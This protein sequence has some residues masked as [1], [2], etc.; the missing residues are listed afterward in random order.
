MSFT[1]E[2]KHEIVGVKLNECCKRAQSAALIQLCSSMV[3]RNQAIE[4]V[5]KTENAQTAKRIFQLI[6][7]RY[8]IDSNLSAAKKTNL[9]KNNV[10]SLTIQENVTNILSDLDLYDD[11][12]F[13]N[14][15]SA[16][17]V[18]KECCARSY[19]A[20]A[21]LASG[22][23]N[24]P[25][26]S[27]YHLE[28]STI[29]PNHAHFTKKLMDRFE[30]N[31][32]ETS[33]RNQN[34][35]YLKSAEKISD[36]LRIVQANSAVLDFEEVRIQRDFHNSLTR[37]DNCEVANEMKTMAAS[38]K[39]V[40]AIQ[41]LIETGQFE[42]LDAMSQEMAQLRLDNPEASLNELCE[43][44]AQKTGI[45]ISKSGMKHRLAKIMN[46]VE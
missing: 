40:E 45:V 15:P 2:V 26:K 46:A 1:Q 34:V 10:Y 3:I 18:S 36:F 35:V 8:R 43:A 41:R 33:R 25:Q 24:S 44:Y 21:F 39:Q 4:L 13:K 5:I 14:H 23:I 22:S 42:S 6:K 28:I 16:K 9:K 11:Q 31:A 38:N 19:L 12:G 7:E 29:D 20:G 17:L 37:L 27:S 32:K 30:L